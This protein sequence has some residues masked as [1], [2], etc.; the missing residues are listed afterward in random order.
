MDTAT[1]TATATAPNH[2]VFDDAGNVTWKYTH[3]KTEEVSEHR[4][5][6]GSW[7]AAL[8]DPIATVYI[9]QG[10]EANCELLKTCETNEKIW[11]INGPFSV[12]R[13]LRWSSRE[14]YSA[15]FTVKPPSS[16]T[17]SGS[18]K[19]DQSEFGVRI[20]L[21]VL[22]DPTRDNFVSLVQ[23]PGHETS[24]VFRRYKEQAVFTSLEGDISLDLT[25]RPNLLE[26]ALIDGKMR[27]VLS[28][29][30][31]LAGHPAAARCVE[32]TC[33]ETP[34]PG[35]LVCGGENPASHKSRRC[36]MVAKGSV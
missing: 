28:G 31:T 30:A 26:S 6:A 1:A 7:G 25:D 14:L 19:G 32:L 11:N 18:A 21:K 33:I 16:A 22:R 9:S 8:F 2:P 4:F 35:E 10:V 17:E 23:S 12:G 5:P 24:D 15:T 27:D 13:D 29:Q 3:P 34:L 36:T 20:K